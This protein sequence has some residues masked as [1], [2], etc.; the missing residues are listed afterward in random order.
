MKRSRLFM[1]V[2]RRILL[3]S[4][5]LPTAAAAGGTLPRSEPVTVA[6]VFDGDTI[7]VLRRGEAVTIRLIGVDTPETSR[8]ETPVQFYG[9]EASDYTR[10]SLLG[11][12][13]TLEFEPKGRPGGD[14]DKYGRTLA[15]VI[16]QGGRNFNL[17]LIRRGY[18]RIY[19]RYP[20]TLQREFL[21]AEREARSAGLGI[22]NEAG[23]AAWSDPARR[24]SIIG[25]SK[26]RI[27]HLPGQQDYDKV[28]EK[29]RIYFQTE[30]EAL[31][32]GFR[33]ALK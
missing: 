24:G 28:G 17:E 1:P 32:A 3:L 8:P 2:F 15:Y 20:F 19:L 22:W 18:G 25:N 6:N 4:I 27:F 21:A 11:A 12:T 26:S 10:R 30:E 5:V 14:R 16:D 13:V 33:K 29:N 9:P 7:V 23:R 31:Q